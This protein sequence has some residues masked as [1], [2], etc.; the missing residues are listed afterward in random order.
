MS[1]EVKVEDLRIDMRRVGWKWG[2][3]VSFAMCPGNVTEIYG[4]THMSRML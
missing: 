4:E 1:I 3:R 2:V